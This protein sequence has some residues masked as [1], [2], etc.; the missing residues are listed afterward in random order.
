MRQVC[1]GSMVADVRP[2]GSAAG[3]RAPLAD[4]ATRVEAWDTVDLNGRRLQFWQKAP[5]FVREHAFVTAEA[6]AD[7]SL[8][9]CVIARPDTVP[10]MI[11]DPL[12]LRPARPPPQYFVAVIPAP[13]DP[14]ATPPPS[15]HNFPPWRKPASQPD[16]AARSADRAARVANWDYAAADASSSAVRGTIT[17][18]R[19]IMP[20]GKKRKKERRKK[21]ELR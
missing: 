20:W 13:G 4:F 8:R 14:T 11:A 18:K 5:R 9:V 15:K 19:R 10:E 17:R 1:S 12:T 6:H 21:G 2:A 7:G 16:G 3:S